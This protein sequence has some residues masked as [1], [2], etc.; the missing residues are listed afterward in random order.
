MT[1]LDVDGG[2]L[3]HNGWDLV[4]LR[5]DLEKIKG[6]P[7]TPIQVNCLYGLLYRYNIPKIADKLGWQVAAVRT[8]LCRNLYV[9]IKDLLKRDRL[10]WDKVADLLEPVYYRKSTVDRCCLPENLV[11]TTIPDKYRAQAIIE[12]LLVAKKN[13]YRRLDTGGLELI[14]NSLKSQLKKR[15]Y[16]DALTTCN[17]ILNVDP[18]RLELLNDIVTCFYHLGLPEDARSTAKLLLSLSDGERYVNANTYYLLGLIHYEWAQQN[19]NCQHVQDAVYYFA[20]AKDRSRL[21]IRPAWQMV[22]TLLSFR[23]RNSCYLLQAELVAKELNY[24]IDDPASNI[25]EKALSIIDDVTNLLAGLEGY[26]QEI[27]QRISAYCPSRS[28]TE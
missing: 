1:A 12:K 3:S 16:S 5:H 20:L 14:L 28:I 18:T 7:L 4:R 26:W 24:I 25:R 8:E 19:Y 22:K 10:S 21:D 6:K 2:D 17:Y 11:A 15:N 23:D 9:Y 27:F 13:S